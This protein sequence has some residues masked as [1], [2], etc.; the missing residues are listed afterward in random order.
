MGQQA[1]APQRTAPR[2]NDTT[3]SQ[4]DATGGDTD[5]SDDSGTHSHTSDTFSLVGHVESVW[6]TNSS[7]DEPEPHATKADQLRCQL[8]ETEQQLKTANDRDKLT[9]TREACD[10]INNLLQRQRGQCMVQKRD[11]EQAQQT[12]AWTELQLAETAGD[13]EAAD[14]EAEHSRWELKYMARELAKTKAERDGVRK[15]CHLASAYIGSLAAELDMHRVALVEA[16]RDLLLRN[17]EIGRLKDGYAVGVM[18]FP[19]TP[20]G[21]QEAADA[22]MDSPELILALWKRFTDTMERL[23]GPWDADWGA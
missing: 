12:L 11:L 9:A 2:R 4:T 6:S 19:P 3:Y 13:L 22:A 23:P 16:E 14:E 18:P 7:E 8:A 1:A 20:E 5:T 17:H 21:L 10:K 15:F